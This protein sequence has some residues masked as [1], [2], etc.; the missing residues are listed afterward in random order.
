MSSNLSINGKKQKRQLAFIDYPFVGYFYCRTFL[1]I[2][3]F[4]KSSQQS[5]LPFS[6]IYPLLSSLDI[7]LKK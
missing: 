2:P 5:G 1:N 3:V 6:F 4:S 7:K